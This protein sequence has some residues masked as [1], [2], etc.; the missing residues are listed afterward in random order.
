V[1]IAALPLAK[2]LRVHRLCER[3]VAINLNKLAKNRAEP[4]FLYGEALFSQTNAVDG[5]FKQA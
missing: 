5:N 1:W 2:T 3:S 4:Y